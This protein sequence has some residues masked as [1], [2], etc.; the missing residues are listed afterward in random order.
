[1]HEDDRTDADVVPSSLRVS[2]ASP[3]SATDNDD[4]PNGVQDD[5]SG[6]GDEA[7]TP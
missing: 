4:A 2:P 6:G 7:A 3:T 1:V 5:S